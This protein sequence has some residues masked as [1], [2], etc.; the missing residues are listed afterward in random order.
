MSL[1]YHLLLS[2]GLMLRGKSMPHSGR[3]VFLSGPGCYLSVPDGGRDSRAECTLPLSPLTRCLIFCSLWSLLHFRPASIWHY[4]SHWTGE[5]RPPARP[6]PLCFPP[7]GSGVV[8]KELAKEAFQ[9]PKIQ[10]ENLM[11]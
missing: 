4:S 8:L 3:E 9:S 1:V 2:P 5:Q 6:T 7:A 11:P 10:Q